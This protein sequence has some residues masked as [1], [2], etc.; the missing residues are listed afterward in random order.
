MSSLDSVRQI[1]DTVLYEG[2]LLYPYRA[3]S[4]KNRVR[5]Q[6]G[7][8]GPPDAQRVGVGEEPA[9][10]VQTLLRGERPSLTVHLRFLQLQM[11]DVQRRD[12]E[13][14]RSVLELPIDGQ[15]VYSWDEA[16]ER[17]LVVGPHSLDSL[18]AG[19]HEQVEVAGGEDV[20][21]AVD[22]DGRIVRRRWPLRA[23]IAVRAVCVA[24]GVHRIEI[25]VTNTAADTISDRDE[26]T[27]VSFIGA[28]LLLPVDDGE[29]IS[30]LDPPDELA[31]EVAA[32]RNRR[33]WPVLAGADGATDLVLG[34]PIIL[35]DYP[36][37]APESAGS[38]FD[39][40]EIDEILTLRVMTLSDEE[41]AQARATDPAAAA[42]IDRCDDMAPADLA[43]MHGV[44]RD[45]HLPVAGEM[46][47]MADLDL[48]GL[49]TFG[50]F[51]SVPSAEGKP[52]WDPG[53]DGSVDPTK[54]V[55]HVNGVAIAKGS[56]VRL[57]PSHRA[58]AQDLFFAG[59]VATVSGVFQ[60]VDGE[61][62]VAVTIDD[63]PAADL[64]DWYGRYLYF[65]TDEVEPLVDTPQPDRLG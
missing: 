38:L 53:V 24:D 1:A 20:S 22:R 32:C 50:D 48:A 40:T 2:Y 5:W 11:R 58:D 55:A 65:A 33:C 16:V 35:Y 10:Q 28:H 12:G 37:V 6:F 14:F 47:A 17:E 59:H 9:M 45:P 4:S 41:K 36:A 15:L 54:D 19:V 3:T 64:H 13:A 25:T 7:V 61:V 18:R 23:E 21:D 57:A 39:A 26:A 8:L 60:D 62:H 31:G 49:P 43:R 52:W 34:S 63:D 46:N 30:A 44:L 51:S 56:K 42:I 29:W 27:R